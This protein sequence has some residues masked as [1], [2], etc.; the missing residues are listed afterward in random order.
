MHL[1]KGSLMQHSRRSPPFRSWRKQALADQDVP[2]AHCP[3][4]PGLPVLVFFEISGPFQW[5]PGLFRAPYIRS[6]FVRV[7]WMW[8]AIAWVREDLKSFTQAISDG[9]V[10]WSDQ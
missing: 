5:K 1:K 4:R 2:I 10:E 6:H 7:W 3:R 9:R 8:F